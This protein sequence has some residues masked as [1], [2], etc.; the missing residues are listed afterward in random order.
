MN[1]INAASMA[2][3]EELVKQIQVQGNVAGIA[4]FGI[5]LMVCKIFGHI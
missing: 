4:E 3:F 2:L 5:I 1:R